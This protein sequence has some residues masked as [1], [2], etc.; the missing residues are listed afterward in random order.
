LAVASAYQTG[1]PDE[2][3]DIIFCVALIHHLDVPRVREEM[4]R[5]VKKG[6]F[7]V[8][9]EPI[10]FSK[11]YD[12]CRKLLPPRQNVSEYEHPL[13]WSEFDYM[14]SGF[15]VENLRYFRLPFVPVTQWL[16]GATNRFVYCLSAWL[17]AEVPA[18]QRFAT[19]AVV[20]LRKP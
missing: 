15:H 3:V 1:L 19:S 12:R 5:I 10:R 17:I 6:G 20:R 8:L 2:S 14:V 9:L 18:L 11:L 7:V 13:T 16:M 4:L